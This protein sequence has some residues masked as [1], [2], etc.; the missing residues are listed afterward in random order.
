M[1]IRSK[2]IVYFLVISL[3]PLIIIGIFNYISAE[4]LLKKEILNKLENI[5]TLGEKNIENVIEE[6]L[7]KIK[8]ISTSLQLKIELDKYN[9]NID[10]NKSQVSM[11]NILNPIKLVIKNFEDIS[12]RDL[13]GTI[14]ASTNKSAIGKN[15]AN[16]KL[17]IQGKKL[18]NIQGK[19]LQ[20][21]ASIFFNDENNKLKLYVGSPIIYNG[22]LIGLVTANYNLENLL[23]IF[24]TYEGLG[25]TGEFILA[26]KNDYGNVFFL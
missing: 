7:E 23:S 24:Q 21:D 22:K 5:A 6:N 19:K 3:I 26:H 9:N 13:T 12:I 2:L 11:N 18:Q 1:K 14:V 4:Q 16:D 15:H 20:N 8:L 10:R 25:E 17:F